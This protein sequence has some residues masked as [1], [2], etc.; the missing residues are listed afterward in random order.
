MNNV[1][2]INQSEIERTIKEF[3]NHIETFE[4]VRSEF[5][6]LQVGD[7]STREQ[8]LQSVANPEAFLIQRLTE[9]IAADNG[10]SFAGFKMSPAKLVDLLD[11]QERAE[12]IKAANFAKPYIW[13]FE[14][15]GT[16]T[17]KGRIEQ[18]K[19]LVEDLIRSYTLLAITERQKVVLEAMRTIKEAAEIL[20]NS[21]YFNHDEILHRPLINF[22]LSAGRKVTQ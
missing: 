17:N 3:N 15:I 7:I 9:R 16:I 20:D 14:K 8:L 12:F 2:F 22:I 10:L 13:P 5:K 21:K 6:D 19:K 4:K 18:D 1:V 11:L